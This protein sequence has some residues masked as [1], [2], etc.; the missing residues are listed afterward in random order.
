MIAAERLNGVATNMTKRTAIGFVKIAG[1]YNVCR[2]RVATVDVD[3]R[4]DG[5][6]NSGSR[7][8]YREFMSGGHFDYAQYRL[9]DIASSIDELIARNDDASMNEYGD[10][11]GAGYSNETIEKFKEASETL[12]RAEAMAQRV[13]WLVSGDD[14]EE[15]FHSRW[16]KEVPGAYSR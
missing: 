11:R 8:C 12:R 5:I 3:L 2:Q 10:T 7:I 1:R 15:S 4:V 9:N 16:A 13:D 6:R 14:G